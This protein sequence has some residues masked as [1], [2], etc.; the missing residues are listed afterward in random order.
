L[1]HYALRPVDHAKDHDVRHTLK[2]S[3]GEISISSNRL[4]RHAD[5]VFQWLPE[6]LEQAIVAAEARLEGK[7][8]HKRDAALVLAARKRKGGLGDM[9]EDAILAAEARLEE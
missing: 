7:H 3:K 4:R 5:R 6:K 1:V 8:P 9:V 2:T